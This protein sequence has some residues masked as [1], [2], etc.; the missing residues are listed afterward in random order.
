M[1]DPNAANI[2]HDATNRFDLILKRVDDV[3]IRLHPASAN[4]GTPMY[5]NLDDWILPS[6][7]GDTEQLAS[8]SSAKPPG[9]TFDAGAIGKQDYISCGTVGVTAF[10]ALATPQGVARNQFQ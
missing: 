5:G 8:S 1:R 2:R 7:Q 6:T 3:C 4:Y 9:A 10:V